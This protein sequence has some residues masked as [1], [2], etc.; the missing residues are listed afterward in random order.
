[1]GA[2]VRGMG[3]VMDISHLDS[4][5]KIDPYNKCIRVQAGTTIES[6]NTVAR[7]YGLRFPVVVDYPE[8]RTIGGIIAEN[9]ICYYSSNSSIKETGGLA[10]YLLSLKV[11]LP[12][13]KIVSLGQNSFSSSPGIIP[14]KLFCGSAG[15]LG[16]ITEATLR[17]VP[18]PEIQTLSIF[19]FHSY[20]DAYRF[21]SALEDTMLPRDNSE[22]ERIEKK[23][24]KSVSAGS[25]GKRIEKSAGKKEA[26]G[27]D[28]KIQLKSPCMVRILDSN[29]YMG[30]SRALEKKGLGQK[31][32]LLFRLAPEAL[33]KRI[34]DLQKI[35]K[36]YTVLAEEIL[37]RLD[38][39]TADNIILSTLPETGP[40]YILLL[41]ETRTDTE[42]EYLM[43][44]IEELAKNSGGEKERE[45]R[46]AVVEKAMDALVHKRTAL[47]AA[48]NCAVP[49]SFEFS[50]P[51]YRI[52]HVLKTISAVYTS[53]DK[54]LET[55]LS[56]INT[57]SNQI[58]SYGEGG[59]VEKGSFNVKVVAES[60]AEELKQ[61]EVE[62]KK[63][64]ET[65]SKGIQKAEADDKGEKQDKVGE[66]REGQEMKRIRLPVAY[67]FGPTDGTF[68]IDILFNPYDTL[69]KNFSIEF[70]NSLYNCIISSEGRVGNSP[71]TSFLQSAQIVDGMPSGDA[72]LFFNKIRTMVDPADIMNPGLYCA[73]YFS[74]FPE[75]LYIKEGVPSDNLPTLPETCP[76]KH[77]GGDKQ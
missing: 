60:I 10:D 32:S 25:T 66:E 36:S 29:A 75:G 5:L 13:G 28:K 49:V 22:E 42:S 71:T 73:P 47:S 23:S 6:I 15:R 65:D 56:I 61:E 62:G 17:L 54:S 70:L 34:K 52:P 27:K 4:I 44:E 26:E 77:A 2:A 50:V 21:V 1:G 46:G 39:E 72:I 58:S 45:F 35:K 31:E 48:F 16:V 41:V 8:I 69:L 9:P 74:R 14:E 11:V 51:L 59:S 38:R 63:K 43:M 67:D 55:S 33:K 76:P 53:L 19:R 57:S 24:I 12:E 7:R 30:Y 68:K 18:L 20:K 37:S 64:N 3:I 40:L